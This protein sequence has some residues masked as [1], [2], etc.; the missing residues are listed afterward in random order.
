[1]TKRTEATHVVLSLQVLSSENAMLAY[2]VI[3]S[4]QRLVKKY[5]KEL[6]QSTWD[7][8][9]DIVEKV[10]K[11]LEVWFTKPMLNPFQNKP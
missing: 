7:V 1:M 5:G 11:Q 4:V 10:L 8:V 6:N 2:E 9:L 3:L